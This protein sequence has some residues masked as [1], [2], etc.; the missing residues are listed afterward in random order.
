ML[1]RGYRTQVDVARQTTVWLI[2]ALP[3]H[4]NLVLEISRLVYPARHMRTGVDEVFLQVILD[5][6]AIDNALWRKVLAGEEEREDGGGRQAPVICRPNHL[7][8]LGW[9]LVCI[10]NDRC[11]CRG[12]ALRIQATRIDGPHGRPRTSCE[13]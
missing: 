9:V 8:Q 10:V 1:R 2:H 4:D 6:H 5:I 7:W 11:L 3:T 13:P 12:E